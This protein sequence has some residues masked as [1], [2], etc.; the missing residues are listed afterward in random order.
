MRGSITP[1]QVSLDTSIAGYIWLPLRF[2][3]GRAVLDCHDESRI[4]DYP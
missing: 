3:E 1:G 4:E 2:E